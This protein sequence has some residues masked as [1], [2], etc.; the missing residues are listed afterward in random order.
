M[1]AFTTL[2]VWAVA[3]TV[4]WALSY[5]PRVYACSVDNFFLTQEG[6]LVAVTP[7]ALN[8]ALAVDNDNKAKLADLVKDGIVLEL[9]GNIK[10]EVLERSIEWKMLKIKLP[11]NNTTYWVKD[12]SLRPINCNK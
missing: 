4:L 3:L 2:R 10:V 11:D 9:K 6:S 8:D 7:Q 12:G 1:G 5:V